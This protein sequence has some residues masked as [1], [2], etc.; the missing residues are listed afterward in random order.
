VPLKADGSFS[1]KVPANVPVHM[2][3]I[4]KFAMS[5]A[6]EPIWI[7]GRPG[8][9]RICGGCHEDRSK[10]TVLPPGTTQAAIDSAVNL[11]TPRAGRVST[12]FS[13]D[14]V[15]G[16]PW[17]QALQP[18]FDAKCIKCHD[19]TPGAANKTFTVMDN[20][21]MTSQTFTFDLRSQKIPLMVGERQ[22]YSFPASYVSLVGL[23]ME[24]GEN[25]VTITGDYKPHIAPGEAAKSD[26]IQKLNPPKRFPT[27]DPNVR[28]FPGPNHPADVGGTELTPDE[29]YLLILNIDMGAQFYFRENKGGI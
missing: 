24:L 27:I 17:D 16:V 18:I 1:A 10:N 19:G 7:S 20:T 6:A 3:L 26:V 15:R 21:L 12:D 8:E 25:S 5:L 13:Y 22:S 11:D 28:A 9:Q 4:D 29:Y 2:Q 23:G 14:K